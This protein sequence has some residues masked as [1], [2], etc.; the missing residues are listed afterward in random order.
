M[1]YNIEFGILFERGKVMSVRKIHKAKY[2]KT[3]GAKHK[4]RFSGYYSVCSPDW[5]VVNLSVRWKK[6]TCSKCLK[7]G[8]K[9]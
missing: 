4:G 1:L 8:G 6:V 2:V 5:A 7:K 9:E 3:A